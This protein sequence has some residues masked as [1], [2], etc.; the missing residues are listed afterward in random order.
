MIDADSCQ[1]CQ[2]QLVQMT[3]KIVFSHFFTVCGEN[4]RLEEAITT[5]IDYQE[6]GDEGRVSIQGV[7]SLFGVCI[8][9]QRLGTG[10]TEWW[11][12][13]LCLFAT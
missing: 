5:F 9:F 2:I 10:D 7:K 11:Q 8:V 6:K 4:K 1:K 13:N 3:K 12:I